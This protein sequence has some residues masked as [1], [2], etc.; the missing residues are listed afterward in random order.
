VALVRRRWFLVPF[1]GL[2]VLLSRYPFAPGQLFTFDDVNLAYSI[3]H[4]DIRASQPQPPGYPLF[5]MEM[6]LLHWLRFRR[7]ESILLALALAGST[8]VLVLVVLAGNRIF[9]GDAGFWAALLFL[10]HPVF[11]HTGLIS[12]LRIQLA[13]LSLAVGAACWRAWRGETRWVLWSALVLGIGAGVRPEAGPVLFP[14]WAVCAWRA[15]VTWRERWRALAGMAAGVLLWLLPAMLASGGPYAFVKTSLD[16][17]SDQGSVSSGLFGASDL[18]WQNTVWRLLVWTGSGL[19]A[20]AMAAVLSWRRRGGWGVGWERAAFLALWFVPPF[21]FALLLHIEDPGQALGMTV[22]VALVCGHFFQRA[23]EILGL[24]IARIHGLVLGLWG[25]SLGWI[26]GV[27]GID[28]PFL[29]VWIPVVSVAAALLLKIGQTKNAGYPPRWMFVPALLIPPLF[30][31]YT[32]FRPNMGWYYA[33]RGGA[34]D[35]ALAGMNTALALSSFQ[36]VDSTLTVDD[37]TLREVRRLAADRPGQTQVVWQQGQASWRKVAYY[38]P[39]VPILVLEHGKL[40]AGSL[41]VMAQWRGPKLEKRV[42]GR[43]PVTVEIPA[44]SRIVWLLD[45]RTDFF[46]EARRTF[47]L[48][49]AGPL[50]FTDLPAGHAEKDLGEYRLIW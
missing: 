9:G 37:H 10:F 20:A 15:P 17:L 12:A 48:T 33:A 21:A 25:I 26:M 35:E 11:W 5:V 43:P 45:P 38:A 2:L 24:W 22:V 6:R 42:E 1:F 8:A 31:N 28:A 44:G 13:L 39:Q 4:F 36:H 16:Y 32:L 29:V 34:W 27:H 47:A 14:L 46:E 19:W 50:W 7:A 3:G 49:P 23:L 41:P 40:R 30:L 18:K